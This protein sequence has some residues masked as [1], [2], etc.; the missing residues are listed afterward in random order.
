MRD[1]LSPLLGSIVV[2]PAL[3]DTLMQTEPSEA[4]LQPVADLEKILVAVRG[5]PRVDVRKDLDEVVEKL[6]IRVSL[7]RAHLR[8][9]LVID[10]GTTRSPRRC[11]HISSTYS[12]LI[13][14]RSHQIWLCY[15][16]LS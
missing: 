12:R 8:F 16:R 15:N 10:E 9:V 4:W 5:G 14:H 7:I 13:E 6:R 2:S 1:G 11:E 3:I